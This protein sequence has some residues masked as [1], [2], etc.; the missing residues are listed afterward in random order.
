MEIETT[1]THETGHLTNAELS[2]LR[3]IGSSTDAAADYRDILRE[4]F[5]ELKSIKRTYSLAYVGRKIGASKGF[6]QQ[7]F[8]KKCHT[9]IELLPVLL[10]V[11]AFNREESLYLVFKF[12]LANS[13]DKYAKDLFDSAILEQSTRLGYSVK[14]MRDN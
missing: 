2:K 12:M 10:K 5:L 11:L 14:A 7:L 4:R 8:S 9:S 3:P 13:Q 1:Q 6:V